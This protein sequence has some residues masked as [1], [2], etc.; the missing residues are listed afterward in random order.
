MR[1]ADAGQRGSGESVAVAGGAFGVG[2]GGAVRRGG[3]GEALRDR[4]GG[5]HLGRCIDGPGGAT[6]VVIMKAAVME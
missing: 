3:V 5:P 1:D 6:V 2:G 4:C